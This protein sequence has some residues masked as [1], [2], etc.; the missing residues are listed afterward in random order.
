MS[1]V[2]EELKAA[3]EEGAGSLAD[4]C[5]TEIIALRADRDAAHTM[6]AAHEATIIKQEH[7]LATL[8]A[9]RDALREALYE[10][11][12]GCQFL[13]LYDEHEHSQRPQPAEQSEAALMH[14]TVA[15]HGAGA[16]D[17][18]DRRRHPDCEDGEPRRP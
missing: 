18:L 11:D 3:I 15:V 10:A 5:L 12:E 2:V 17:S 8:R 9:E 4:A 7:E 13:H 14:R 1:D 6:V 16:G